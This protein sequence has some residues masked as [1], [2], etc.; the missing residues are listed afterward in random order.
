M[1]CASDPQCTL[2]QYRTEQDVCFNKNPEP[3]E[4][5]GDG[6]NG[7]LAGYPGCTQGKKKVCIVK[8]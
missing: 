2:F 3:Y 1:R 8:P 7:D 5:G 4:A 6:T